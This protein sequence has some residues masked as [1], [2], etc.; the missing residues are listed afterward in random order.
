[1]ALRPADF[2]SAAYTSSATWA[3][4]QSCRVAAARRQRRH[5][6]GFPRRCEARIQRSQRTRIFRNS[7]PMTAV[8]NVL[9]VMSRGEVPL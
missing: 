6:R 2:E 1:M 7:Q 8:R 5:Y 9:F 4:R 3:H